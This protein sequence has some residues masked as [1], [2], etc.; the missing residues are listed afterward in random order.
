MVNINQ[1]YQIL[2]GIIETDSLDAIYP[3]LRHLGSFLGRTL[4]SPFLAAEI[5]GGKVVPL[6]A[7]QLPERGRALITLLPEVPH[8]TNWDV[9]EASLGVFPRPNVGAKSDCMTLI[10]SESPAREYAFHLHQ[11]MFLPTMSLL[12]E[13]GAAGIHLRRG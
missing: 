3:I 2:A 10:F 5:A 12:R 4:D 9:V 8:R 1:A 13:M 11:R 7:G 6:E